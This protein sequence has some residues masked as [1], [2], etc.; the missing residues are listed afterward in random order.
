MERNNRTSPA[1]GDTRP[2][3]RRVCRPL[4][5]FPIR[6][7]AP[8]GARA[9]GYCRSPL[10]GLQSDCPTGAARRRQ[11]KRRCSTN[12]T[13]R[14]LWVR[15]TKKVAKPTRSRNRLKPS[16]QHPN[17]ALPILASPIE[18]EHEVASATLVRRRA[19]VACASYAGQT[20]SASRPF[21]GELPHQAG[22]DGRK[23]AI[24]VSRPLT[25]R[26]RKS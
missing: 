22:S 17:L 4:R 20:G 25:R 23:A 14:H 2:C 24:C 8:P 10:T 21:H 3:A 12:P 15:A 13:L 16:F 7:T 1:R 19:S 18:V 6:S 5:G 9:P 26:R 11:K